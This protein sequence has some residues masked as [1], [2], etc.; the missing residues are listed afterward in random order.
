MTYQRDFARR[1]RVGV[2]GLG[3]DAYRN[4]LPTLHYLPVQLTALCDIDP[5]LLARTALEYGIEETFTEAAELFGLRSLDAVLLCTGP[6]HHPE[7]AM[8]AMSAGLHVWMEKPPAMRAVSVQS[9]IAARGDR[10]CAVGFK[11]AYMPAARKAQELLANPDFGTLRSLL[12]VYPV[13]IPRHGAVALQFPKESSFLSVGCHPLS[14]MVALGGPVESVTTLRGPG[15][16]AV[17]VVVLHFANGAIGNFHLAGGSPA[18]LA[19]ERYDLYGDGGVISIENS[20]KI[21][22]HRGVPFDYGSQRDFTAP[23]LDSGSVVWESSNAQGTLE[24]T[25]LFVQGMYGELLDFCNAVLEGREVK[26]G[27][28]EFALHVMQIYEAAMLS[29]GQPMTIPLEMNLTPRNLHPWEM[30]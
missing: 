15:E 20:V 24:N 18:L 14:L 29:E 4:V 21:A 30:R 25:S 26:V 17:G 2:V 7:L 10:I 9:M 13:T 27:T 22:Y 5:D 12:A 28:L 6:R 11:K 19:R 23:G 16:E 1:L 3:G 8:A